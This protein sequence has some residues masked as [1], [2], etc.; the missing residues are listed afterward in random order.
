VRPPGF[1]LM[2]RGGINV[3]RV[4][5]EL[6]GSALAIYPSG[7][8]A[9]PVLDPLVRAG[10]R[11]PQL[12]G[13]QRSGLDTVVTRT[14]WAPPHSALVSATGSR[15]GACRSGIEGAVAHELAPCSPAA[16]VCGR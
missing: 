7:G 2:A 13:T 1:A 8:A 3:A 16:S 5:E 10:G 11:I 9:A 4:V 15:G 6:G 12:A 14:P